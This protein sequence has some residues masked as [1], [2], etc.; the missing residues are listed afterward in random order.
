MIA[1]QPYETL[2]EALFAARY[3]ARYQERTLRLFRR[4][5]TTVTFL[6]LIGGSAAFG[7]WLT[8]SLHLGAYMG[9]VLAV[10]AAIN[11]SVRP[12]ERAAAAE[13]R[14]KDYM[15]LTADGARMELSDL[16]KRLTDLLAEDTSHVEALREVAY[17]DVA[18]EY[19]RTESLKPLNA[20]ETVAAILS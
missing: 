17:N 7:A 9:L 18:K 16:N 8:S 1:M 2:Y 5:H 19:G 4:I 20:W 11:H 14:Y 12:Y 6:E 3:A 15:R 13:L 10:C